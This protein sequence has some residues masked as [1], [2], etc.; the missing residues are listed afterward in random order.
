MIR[1]LTVRQPWAAAIT[2]VDKR[3]ENRV[4]PTSHR[5]PILIH[6]SATVDRTACRHAPLA[7]VV[8]GLQLD[9]KAVVAVARI[10]GC[11]E[12]DGECTPW[13]M[14]GH[15]HWSLDSVTALPLPVPWGGAQRLWTPPAELL[16]TV[17]MQLDDD[18]AANLADDREWRD[19]R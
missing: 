16:K 7:A 19:Q 6:S 2:Y 15:F 1:A 4:W 18:T 12:D 11:H 13:S 14:A 8:R 3:V 9:L 10:T 17:R 5:G